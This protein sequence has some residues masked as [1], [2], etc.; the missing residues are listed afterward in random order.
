MWAT[1][2]GQCGIRFLDLPAEMRRKI[3]EWILGDL[4]EG[5]SLHAERSGAMFGGAALLE[6]GPLDHTVEEDDGL[7]ISGTAAKVIPLPLRK[8]IVD[9]NTDR[10]TE[11]MPQE[12]GT[13]DWLSQPLSARGIALTIDVLVFTAALLMFA[14]IFLS[15]IGE[16]PRWPI[17]MAIVA[18][19]S[20]AVMYWGF[21]WVF[22][23][24]SLGKRLACSVGITPETR[25]ETAVGD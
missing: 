22:G 3:N 16:A 1:A 17:R 20:V 25:K 14:L 5:I 21:F 23:G 11:P 10:V 13:L 6:A 18:A 2:S 9:R 19:A 4:L 8:K 15:V 24:K 7:L 12:V